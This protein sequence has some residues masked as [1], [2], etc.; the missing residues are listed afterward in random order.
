MTGRLAEHQSVILWKVPLWVCLIVL[1][2]SD[3]V[4]GFWGESTEVR[5]LLIRHVTPT[6]CHWA[7]SLGNMT[8]SLLPEPVQPFVPIRP[9]CVCFVL[10]VMIWYY[11][12]YFVVRIVP[13]LAIRLSWVGP[14]DPL[15]RPCPLFS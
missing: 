10:W 11:V 13:V 9:V 14:W 2:W 6:W 7:L 8:I 12:I 3:R 1:L 15:T 5:R 4:M